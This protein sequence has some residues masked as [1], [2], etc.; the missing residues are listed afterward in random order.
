VT[1]PKSVRSA[2]LLV[3]LLAACGGPSPP[4][5]LATMP[6]PS[7][8]LSAPTMLPT[9]Q[10]GAL[11]SGT[12]SPSS[13]PP[14]E[15]CTNAAINQVVQRFIV[16]FN[17]GDQ[18]Q[19]ARFFGPRFEGYS[20]HEGDPQHGGRTFI[21]YGPSLRGSIAPADNLTAVPREGL[22]PL[23]AARHAH[24]E[25]LTLQVADGSYES[26]RNIFNFGLRLVR[27]ADDIP[28]GLGG[29]DHL[30]GA[31]GSIDC[32]DQTI[33]IWGMF[34]NKADPGAP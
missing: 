31:K 1:M 32:T 34:Q 29:P 2:V 26:L 30:A 8:T 3:V 28:P 19:L 16:A 33:I 6:S 15:S 12:P 17:Q 22:L 7:P 24:G 4:T 25:R 9:P 14:P 11:S 23:L 10:S 20:I 27:T 13:A 21:A 18:A 5:P